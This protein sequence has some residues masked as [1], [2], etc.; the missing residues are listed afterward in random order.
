MNYKEYDRHYLDA[1]YNLRAVVPTFQE[2]FD[3]WDVRSEETRGRYQCDLDI[4]Y[5]SGPLECL[6]IF[7]SGKP[8]SP[9]MVFIHG[10]YWQGSDKSQFSF[11]AEG[12]VPIGIN[13]VAANYSLAPD[14]GMDEIV[15]QNRNA[16]RWVWQHA[17]EFGS[18]PDKIFASGHSA[19]GHLT[20]MLASTDWPDFGAGLPPNLVKGICCISGIFDLEPIRSCYLNDVLKMNEDVSRHNSPIRN[21]PKVKI[22][23]ILSVG[24]LETDAFQ[25]QSEH[26]AARWRSKGLPLEEIAMPGFHHFNVVDELANP[27]SPLNG[28]V[29]RQIHQANVVS[30]KL[31]T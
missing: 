31:P 28:A 8:N 15:S 16:L 10:G 23:L 7:P 11:L 3:R 6:D 22:P 19:G 2:H 14:A 5:S 29:I 1:Q 27:A 30:D 4:P 12:F 25:Q 13:F 20:A 17:A 18:D 21:L 26:Y 24:G 9:V